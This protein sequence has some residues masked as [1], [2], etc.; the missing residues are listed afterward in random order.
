MHILEGYINRGYQLFRQRVADG[1]HM[2]TAQVEKIAQ[3]HVFAGQDAL[4]IHLVDQLGG[5]DEAVA[6]AAQLAKLKEY[7]TSPYPA[8]ASWL[9]QLVGQISGGNYLDEGIRSQLHL[10]TSQL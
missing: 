4:R 2:T 8:P 7:H 6:K 9:D 1:R 5:L 10:S 3:G